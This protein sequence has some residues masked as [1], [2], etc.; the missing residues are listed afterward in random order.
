MKNK[1]NEID[2]LYPEKQGIIGRVIKEIKE[3]LDLPTSYKIPTTESERKKYRSKHWFWFNSNQFIT[4]DEINE[5]IDKQIWLISFRKRILWILEWLQYMRNMNKFKNEV[6][7][8][9]M[10]RIEIKE[11]LASYWLSESDLRDL[12]TTK[13]LKKKVDKMIEDF[14]IKEVLASWL[15]ESDLR[16]LATTKRLKE[17]VDKMIEDFEKKKKKIT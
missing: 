16:D 1:P 2:F 7:T 10:T 11:L 17:K 8:E 12:A 13:R 3:L 4:W 9:G 15:S 6:N 5:V 14:K